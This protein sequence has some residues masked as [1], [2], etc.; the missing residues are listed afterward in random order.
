VETDFSNIT[1]AVEENF[2]VVHATSK[3]TGQPYRHACPGTDFVTIATEIDAAG[4]DGISREDLHAKTGIP[5]TR[6]QVALL[7]LNE[8]GCIN[9]Q[10]RRGRLYARS[11]NFM[12]EDAMIEYHA[13]RELG[14]D[15]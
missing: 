4:P 9:R 2:L 3:R 5:W 14:K 11:S 13:L 8:R 10:G 1:F 15:A 7:F 12:F 6:I